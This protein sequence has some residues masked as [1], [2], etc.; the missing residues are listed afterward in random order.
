MEQ[1]TLKQFWD[2]EGIELS[3]AISRLKNEGCTVRETMTTQ[4]IANS[5]GEH[6]REFRN[7]IRPEH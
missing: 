3:L 4:E 6:P 7:I 2:E 5:K 1:K